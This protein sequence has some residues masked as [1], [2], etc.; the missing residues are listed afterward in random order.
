MVYI[1]RRVGVSCSMYGMLHTD[2]K[3][4]ITMC[5]LEKLAFCHCCGLIDPSN[6]GVAVGIQQLFFT[7]FTKL[8]NLLHKHE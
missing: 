5:K 7:A 4:Y 6:V 8:Q 3:G 2:A 1:K